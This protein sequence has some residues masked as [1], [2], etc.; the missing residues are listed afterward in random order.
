MLSGRDTLGELSSTLRTA[1]RELERLDREL[2]STSS[3]AAANR[4]QQAQAL[5]RMAATR[6]DAI[7]Q[8]DVVQQIDAADYKVR[9]IL[10]DRE[11]AMI[12]LNER[13]SLA[14][15]ALLSLEER[16]DELHDEVDVAAQAL[17][18]REAAVQ[19][20]LESEP[21]FQAQLDQTRKTDAV[22]ISAAEKAQVVVEDRR[23]KGKPFESD[24]LFMYLWN[25]GYGTSEYRANPLARLLDAWV[26]RLCK[27][28]DARPNYWMLLEIPKRLTEH[29]E[30]K[31]ANAD[32]EL[33]RLQAM[34]LEAARDGGVEV[35]KV[36]ANRCRATTGRAR[37]TDSRVG[38]SATSAADRTKPVRCG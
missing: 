2:Q 3:S 32:S 17:A 11:D 8:G 16:R 14:A 10:D 13:V 19:S 5:K 30:R 9:K 33:D 15:K 18:E 20:A 4:Q 7:R 29:A 6:L 25:R 28:Q 24:P 22:A 27:Y 37:R 31:R 1:R 35:A 23:D 12:A 38:K 26:A 36:G 34:E 21:E